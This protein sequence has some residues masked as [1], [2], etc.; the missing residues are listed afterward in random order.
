[1]KSFKDPTTTEGPDLKDDKLLFLNGTERLKYFR[2]KRNFE[3]KK[4]MSRSVIQY[5]KNLVNL[6]SLVAIELNHKIKQLDLS[7]PLTKANLISNLSKNREHLPGKDVKMAINQLIK[8]M[9][10]ALSAGER[11]EVR[12][13]GSFSLHYYP[14]RAG[15]NPKSGEVVNLSGKYVPYFK[16]GKEL[17]ERVKQR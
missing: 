10:K 7:P 15:R 6:W 1:M 12:G 5:L 8:I 13:F 16:P 3:R 9:S 4:N 11:I 2:G 14:P 17:R